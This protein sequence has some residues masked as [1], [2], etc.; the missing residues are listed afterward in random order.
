MIEP[1]NCFLLFCQEERK[2]ISL[3][4]KAWDNSQVTSHLGELWREM[5]PKLKLQYKMRAARAKKNFAANNPNFKRKTKVESSYISSFR[6][7]GPTKKISKP[8]KP[9]RPSPFQ[10]FDVPV[11]DVHYPPIISNPRVTCPRPVQSTPMAF[12]TETLQQYSHC[13]DSNSICFCDLFL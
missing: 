7:T 3:H 4:C 2:T 5:D 11:A 1:V 10:Y 8:A 12:P 9:Q 13:C 6:L